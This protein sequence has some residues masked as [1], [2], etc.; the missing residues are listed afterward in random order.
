MRDQKKG[1]SLFCFMIGMFV[2]SCDDDDFGKASLP[3]EIGIHHF[4]SAGSTPSV[5]VN[6][7]GIAPLTAELNL[8]TTKP[9]KASI[10]VLGANPV[11]HDFEGLQ[12]SHT[13]PILGLYPGRMNQVIVSVS[14]KE[15]IAFDT[16]EI[17]PDTLPTYLPNIQIEMAKTVLM[18]PGMN[19]NTLSISDGTFFQPYPMMYDFNG[20]IRWV[21]NFEGIHPGFVAPMERLANG[22]LLFEDGGSILEYD[23]M[24]RQQS[25]VAMPSVYEA[26]HD[27]I[28]MPSGNYLVAVNKTGSQVLHN[29]SMKNS[30]EDFMIEIDGNSGALIHE[31]DF[32]EILDVDRSNFVD[33]NSQL[34]YDWFHMNAVYY[35]PSDDCF[36]VSGQRQGLVKVD[37]MNN[38]KWILAPHK[39]WGNAGFDGNGPPTSPFLLTAI[40]KLNRPFSNE[41]QEGTLKHSD[42]NWTWGQH[43][44][45]LLPN[46][47]L[48]V[49]D[50]GLN[51]NFASSEVYSRAVEYQI[52]ELD[53][54]I[55]EVWSYGESRGLETFSAIISD[56]DYLPQTGNIL[57]C[58]GIRLGHKYSKIVELS[59]PSGTKVF[60]ATMNFKDTR[61]TGQG[62]GQFDLTYRAERLSL[63]P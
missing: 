18:E 29:G 6:P 34:S 47:N 63:Y 1:L 7:S 54:T 30:V 57:F 37:R 61:A 38:L 45:L 2:V 32:R 13:L 14:N 36:I 52:N 10:T 26:H 55:K 16:I 12:T 41:V 48:L 42:F 27:V 53:G 33:V 3:Q 15:Y 22:N 11:H 40:D 58:P 51:R 21:L 35:S 4:L 39:G 56:V 23:M 24:G 8:S 5:S 31:W 50:N 20:D 46:G 28:K 44:P 43:A 60:E 17:M 49:F 19:L 62:F 9:S 59:Y 25:S